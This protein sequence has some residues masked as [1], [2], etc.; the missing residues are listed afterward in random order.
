MAVFHH[1]SV[2][3]GEE[4]SVVHRSILGGGEEPSVVVCLVDGGDLVNEGHL[5]PLDKV[6]FHPQPFKLL[7]LLVEVGL[8]EV[9]SEADDGL[10]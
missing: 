8:V 4:P 3:G 2:L 9:D 5:F 1:C 6:L 10:E 7:G